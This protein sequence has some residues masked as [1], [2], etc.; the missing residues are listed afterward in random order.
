[1]WGTIPSSGV[2]SLLAAA[3]LS[4]AGACAPS[5]LFTSIGTLHLRWCVASPLTP[6]Q[7]FALF[8]Q[9]SFV[10]IPALL[11]A[12]SGFAFCV[13]LPSARLTPHLSPQQCTVVHHCQQWPWSDRRP[14]AN[15]LIVGSRADACLLSDCCSFHHIGDLIDILEVFGLPGYQGCL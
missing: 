14:S 9:A 4:L 3:G 15:L 8:G 6:L 5:S 13:S 12:A 11:T 2:C 1:M 7:I 10:G